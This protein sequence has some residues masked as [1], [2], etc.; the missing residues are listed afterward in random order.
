MNDTSKNRMSSTK[1]SESLSINHASLN[2]QIKPEKI[3]EK[4]KSNVSSVQTIGDHAL[5]LE[6][7]K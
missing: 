4:E 2:I 5:C 7:E 3:V 1:Q 6:E